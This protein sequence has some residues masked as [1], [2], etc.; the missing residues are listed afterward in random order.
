MIYQEKQLIW[1]SIKLEIVLKVFCVHKVHKLTGV[2]GLASGGSRQ[3]YEVYFH[4][5]TTAGNACD[6]H[7]RTQLPA[8]TR[9]P[10]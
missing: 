10:L 9:F 3:T 4:D 7:L 1:N 6:F 8:H 2:W 5:L